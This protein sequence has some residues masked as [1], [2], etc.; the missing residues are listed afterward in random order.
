VTPPDDGLAPETASTRERILDVALELFIDQG[1]EGTSLRELA[2]KLGFT[3]AA[4]YYHFASK[5]DI[6]L[7][8]H[9][10]IHDVG[11]E[12]LERLRDGADLAA[13]ESVLTTVL[14]QMLAQRKLFLMHARNQAALEKLHL[15]PHQPE[16]DDLQARFQQL[17][18]DRAVPLQDRVRMAASFGAVLSVLFLAGG[19]FDGTSE[20]ELGALLRQTIHSVLAG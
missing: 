11:R 7:A 6:L 9:M 3:K 2:E 14:D 10:R 17:L 4:L 16:H 1:Y 13:F 20:Q 8:L 15:K 5:E 18:A 19:A 12:G